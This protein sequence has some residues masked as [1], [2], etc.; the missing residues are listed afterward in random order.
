MYR[1]ARTP[2]CFCFTRTAKWTK[3][4]Q[5]CGCTARSA[6]IL[7]CKHHA[8]SRESFS[9]FCCIP[10]GIS[11]HERERAVKMKGRPISPTSHLQIWLIDCPFGSSV[12]QSHQLALI[13][14]VLLRQ[15]DSLDVRV[16]RL[17][18]GLFRSGV[19]RSQRTEAQVYLK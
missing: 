12:I 3:A 18:L 8:R 19:R 13:F 17:L 15:L 6:T 14:I 7:S 5:A 11:E 9:A 10:K 16:F 1:R 2:P 4:S